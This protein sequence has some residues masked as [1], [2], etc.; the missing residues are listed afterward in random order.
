MSLALSPAATLGA[1]GFALIAVCYGFARFAFGLFLPQVDAEL[2]LSST[3]SGLISGGA[4]LGYCIA[5]ALSAYLTERVGPRAVAIVAALIAAAG[6]AGIAAA[7]SAPWLAGA[8]MLAGSSTGLASPPLAA[9]V[10]AAVKPDRQ[11]ATN[12]VINAGTGAGVVLS[13]PVALM[14]GDQ[15]RL[16]YSG[17]AVAAVGLAFAAAL[18]LPRGSQTVTNNTH[19]LPSLNGEL[20]RLIAAAFLTGAASTAI[21]SFGAQLVALRLDWNSAGAGLLW[22][23]IGAA[24]IAGA[25]AGHLIARF[26]MDRVHHVFLAAMAAGILM[27]GIADTSA[28]LT[29]GGGLL[30]GAAYIMLTGVYLLWGV[31]ALPDR[32]ATGVTI[33]FLALAIG[34]TA[35]AAVFGLLME[36]LTA[37]YAVAIFACLALTAGIARAE[38]ANPRPCVA[39]R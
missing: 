6:M 17:F 12:T 39:G 19:G 36:H 32:P 34:Q 16:A 13:G 21:W 24:G 26:G 25:S 1:T 7:P 37:N 4:F 23:A 38:A 28:A 3:L 18:T 9:A 10:T 30:F 27:I 29:L 33:A 31:Q 5:I 35:G 22:I 14:M 20:R 2:S 15:W 11:N 8:V